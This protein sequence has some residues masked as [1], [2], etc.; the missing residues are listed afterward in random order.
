MEP[1]N[2]AHCWDLEKRSNLW[3]LIGS[4]GGVEESFTSNDRVALG[5]AGQD[6]QLIDRVWRLQ[7]SIPHRVF[8]IERLVGPRGVDGCLVRGGVV[9]ERSKSGLKGSLLPPSLSPDFFLSSFC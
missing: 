1:P 6:G 2:S 7:L 3:N 8:A 5:K 9:F 4:F